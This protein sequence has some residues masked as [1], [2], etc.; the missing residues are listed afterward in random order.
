MIAIFALPAALLYVMWIFT[1][2]ASLIPVNAELIIIAII[3]VAMRGMLPL[4]VLSN[5]VIISRAI[6]LFGY[7]A[8]KDGVE[9]SIERVE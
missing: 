5:E 1:Y 3:E 2:G 7:K 8:V 9:P 6:D 4:V